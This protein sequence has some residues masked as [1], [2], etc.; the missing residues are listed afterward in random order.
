MI[1]CRLSWQLYFMRVKYDGIVDTD[2]L[3]ALDCTI[4]ALIMKGRKTEV[5]GENCRNS[6]T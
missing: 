3:V 2:R 5:P 6:I 4:F 1:H